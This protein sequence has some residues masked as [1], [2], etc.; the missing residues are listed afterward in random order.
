MTINAGQA[1]VG[2]MAFG[3]VTSAVGTYFESKSRKSSLQFQARMA[4][5][6]ARLSESAAQ[7][8]LRQGERAVQG[9]RMRTAQV[10]SA[11][12]VGMAANGITLDSDSAVDVLTT[13]DVMGEQDAITTETNAIAQAW[14]HRTQSVNAQT[15]ADMNR[16]SANS[17]NP[18]MA[19]A[20]SL[21]GNAG[22]VAYSWY[23]L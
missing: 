15:T 10:K 12:R 2:M 17:M 1:G 14:G 13:T 5:I 16:V 8:T 9:V 22:Q 21:L 7:H 6:N 3:A 11:Q 20:G 23:R 19:A 18:G 4:E